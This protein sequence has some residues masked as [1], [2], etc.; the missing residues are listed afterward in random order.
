MLPHVSQGV[1]QRCLTSNMDMSPNFVPC[2]GIRII[3][4]YSLHCFEF[5]L[6]VLGTLTLVVKF[7]PINS[8]IHVLLM[9]YV[10]RG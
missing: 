10:I 8:C 5:V 4:C 2:V 9:L 3:S 1:I 7:H 6:V